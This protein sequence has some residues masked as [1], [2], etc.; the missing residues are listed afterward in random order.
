M[1]TR[2]WISATAVVALAAS[3]LSAC[4]GSD[5]KNAGGLEKTDLT[6]ATLPTPDAATL[7]LAIKKGYFKAEG[8]DVKPVIIGNGADIVQRVVSGSADFADSGY[9]PIILAASHGVRLK[10]VVDAYQGRSKLY[11]IMALPSSGIKDAKGLEGKKIG[12]INTKG[13]PA[14]LTQSALKGAGVPANSVHYVEVQLPAMA[15]ALKNKSIDAAFMSDPYVSQIEQQLGARQVVDTMS[16]PT[17]DLAVGGYIASQ[18]YTQQNPKTV[19]AF[20]R[21]MLKA[22]TDAQD[23]NEISGV[24]PTYIKGLQP[25]TAQTINLGTFPTSLNKTRLQRVADLM[26][27][28][29]QLKGH[30]DVQTLL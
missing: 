9:I 17:A 16:G 10:I 3:L 28:Y 15:A 27:Q 25:Q 8:L 12:I 30:F 19:A 14:L 7:Y 1:K 18:R 23:R 13:F 11:P 4:G 26:T 20:K 2:H 24:L 29:G 5:K 22:Q 6:V 21:A